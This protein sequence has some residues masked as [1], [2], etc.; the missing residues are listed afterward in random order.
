MDKTHKY[1]KHQYS[2]S[3]KIEEATVL[4][5]TALKEKLSL[6]EAEYATISKK[7]VCSDGRTKVDTSLYSGSG[8]VAFVYY[9]VFK[10][11][12]RNG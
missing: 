10:Y 9:E 11:L 7:R 3:I 4:I 2:S 5:K 6:Y 1:I 12:R 8:G